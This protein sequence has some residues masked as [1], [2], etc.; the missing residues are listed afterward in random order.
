[1][2][3]VSNS[4][5]WFSTAQGLWVYD[6][7]GCMAVSDPLLKSLIYLFVSRSCSSRM[8]RLCLGVHRLVTSGSPPPWT[9]SEVDL[10][11]YILCLLNYSVNNF[12]R[13]RCLQVFIAQNWMEFVFTLAMDAIMILRIYALFH[14]SKKVL[15]FLVYYVMGPGSGIEGLIFILFN[16]KNCQLNYNDILYGY[17]SVSGVIFE[18][19]L[20]LFVV[21][22]F[23]MHVKELRARSHTWGAYE[24]LALLIRDNVLYFVLYVVAGVLRTGLLANFTN[25][26]GGWVFSCIETI[27]ITLQQYLFSPRLVLAYRQYHADISR[28]H[29]R[30]GIELSQMSNGTRLNT[31]VFE[32]ASITSRTVGSDV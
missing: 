2:P 12:G 11:W 22:C 3:F 8:L 7:A 25:V 27:I 9:R 28:R 6:L 19:I 29:E 16:T 26:E 4:P 15:V 1:M 5:E 20:L 31:I 18:I 30:G 24:C 10:V 14:R 23:F 13:T 32:P 21:K 17:T